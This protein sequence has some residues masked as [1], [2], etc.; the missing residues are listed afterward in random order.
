MHRMP[1]AVCYKSTTM[2]PPAFTPYVVLAL[3]VAVVST[4]SILIRFAQAPAVP[5]LTIAAVRLALAAMLLT[6]LVWERASGELHALRRRDLVL[7]LLSGVALAAHFWSW[8]ASLAYT[9]VASSTALVTTNPLWV[10]LASMLIL[11]E[12]PGRR[13]MGGIVLTLAGGACIFASDSSGGGAGMQAD[14]VR[15]NLLALLGA[16]A[17]SAYLLIGRALR[18]RVG[19]LVYI[20]LAY[21]TAALVL[22][23]VVGFAGYPLSG[24]STIAYA[25]M[26]GLAL[27][28]QLLGHTAFNWALRHLSATFVAVSIL[29]E[30]VGSA[31][32]ALL[33]FGERFAP[34][35]LAGFALLLAGIF[36]AARGEPDAPATTAAVR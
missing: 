27:G 13:T 17:A 4:A 9:S 10:G 1:L 26:I 16:L 3:G 29:G 25:A 34:L 33:I 36:L 15:G 12:R 6:P 18:P 19:L 35:Q 20:W 23:L 28:P 32:L 22:M 11:G 24:Y 5:S 30:P 2:R 7:A 31:L 21:G 14:P 8:I